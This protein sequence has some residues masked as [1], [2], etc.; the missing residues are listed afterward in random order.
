MGKNSDLIASLFRSQELESY[1][2]QEDDA[3]YVIP[4]ENITLSSFQIL[5]FQEIN[6]ASMNF[7]E[8]RAFN[9]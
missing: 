8:T 3:V 5:I 9:N 2:S 4:A 1:T 6:D 7:A